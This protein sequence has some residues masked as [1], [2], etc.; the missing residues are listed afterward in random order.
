MFLIGSIHSDEAI[1]YVVH[2]RTEFYVS[3]PHTIKTP[4]AFIVILSIAH[5]RCV[6][7]SHRSV[8]IYSRGPDDTS[9]SYV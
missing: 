8:T 2:H 7:I 6:Y 9:K 5:C 3:F 4:I 1:V